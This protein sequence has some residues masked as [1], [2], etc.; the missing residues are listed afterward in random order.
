MAAGQANSL[1]PTFSV[2][3]WW[4]TLARGMVVLF[5][6]VALLAGEN[7]RTNIATFF[8]AY[9]I[10]TGALAIQWALSPSREQRPVLV[11]I[12][13]VVGLTTG[14][15]VMARSLFQSLFSTE[16]AVH[17]VGA[18]ALLVGILRIG[19]GFRTEPLL[20]RRWAWDSFLLGAFEVVLGVSLLAGA[21]GSGWMIDA[22][23][24]WAIVGGV[25]LILDALQLRRAARTKT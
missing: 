6:G 16:F 4:I 12:S 24:A 22:L 18:T 9:W 17:L 21:A 11:L 19:R 10:L 13:G 8:G 25:V 2:R 1:P 7:T 5:Q 20:H 14:V 3:F 23:S 15:V